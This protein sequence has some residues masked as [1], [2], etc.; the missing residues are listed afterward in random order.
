MKDQSAIWVDNMI[1]YRE[2]GFKPKRS[3]KLALTCGEETN[4][5]LNGAGWLAKNARNEIDAEFGLTEGTDGD[6]DSKGNKIAL[7]VLAEQKTSQNYQFQVTNAGGHSSRPVP[8]NAIYHLARAVDKVS[9]YE[10]PVQID[11]ANRAY[12]TGMSKIVGAENSAAMIGV[13]KNPNDKSAVLSS[14]KIP[15]GTPCCA[16]RAWPPCF[17]R[18]T[19]QTPCRSARWP[20]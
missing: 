14:I 18:A 16:R 2:E 4:S 8:D 19:L 15:T 20:T 11:D 13:V 5:A 12:F 6:L 1:R 3:I 7:E 17:P 9:H 10:F